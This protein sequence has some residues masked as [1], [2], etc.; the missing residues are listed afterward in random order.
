[1]VRGR[2]GCGGAVSGAGH[3]SGS[4]LGTP[5]ENPLGQ[6]DLCCHGCWLLMAPYVQLIVFFCHV[7]VSVERLQSWRRCEFTRSAAANCF[8][9]YK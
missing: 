5:K 1:M 9:V 7:G 4:S 8:D 2:T 3:C 6:H